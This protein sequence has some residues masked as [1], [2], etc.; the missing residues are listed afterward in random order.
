M[1][2]ASAPNS[3]ERCP[4]WKRSE[5]GNRRACRAEIGAR[6]LLVLAQ[7]DGPLALRDLA[8]AGK[9]P[10][11]KTHRYLVSLCR[12]GLAEQDGRNGLYDLGPA[13]LTIGLAAQYRLDEFR[14][15]DQA[16]DHLFDATR[17]TVGLAVWGDHGPTVLRRREGLHA[18]TVT[19]RVGSTMSTVTTNAGRV[20]AAFLPAHLS[21][22]IIDAEFAVGQV[23]VYR[24][25]KLSRS[26]FNRLLDDIRR[27]GWS[28]TSGD[29][30]KG[31]DAVAMP[32]FGRESNVLMTL[33]LMGAGAAVDLSPKG[34]AFQQLKTTADGLSERLGYRR[35][36]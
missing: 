22:P 3:G 14:L 4:I 13:A 7:A 24:G 9:L 36:G 10:P 26:A 33:S 16:V 25:K 5:S 2:I 20:F 8:V 11:S 32:V 34:K 15:A 27:Q 1:A 23:P 28:A 12:A 30:F 6:L 17:L 35:P 18:V 31:L 19:R 21:Q 29:T